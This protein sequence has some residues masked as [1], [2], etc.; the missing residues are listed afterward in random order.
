MTCFVQANFFSPD[1]SR[2]IK[3]EDHDI[4]ISTPHV[5]TPTLECGGV[6]ML[7]LH[8]LKFV[9]HAAIKMHSIFANK[10]EIH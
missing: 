10:D 9:T 5:D 6:D 7:P 3:L 4:N 1:Y 2:H 8:V